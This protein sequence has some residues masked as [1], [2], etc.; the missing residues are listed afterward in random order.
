M[1][2]VDLEG[3]SITPRNWGREDAVTWVWG[4]GDHPNVGAEGK[5]KGDPLRK[6]QQGLGP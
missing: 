3:S 4:S 1:K 6:G 2:V 5:D